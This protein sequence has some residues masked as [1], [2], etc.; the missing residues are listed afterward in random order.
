ML[1]CGV[2]LRKQYYVE[3]LDIPFGKTYQVRF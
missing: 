3:E 1:Q 2:R